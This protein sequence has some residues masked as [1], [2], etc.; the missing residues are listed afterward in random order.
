M[1][2]IIDI[3]EEVVTAIQNGED[4]RYDIHTAIAQ[5]IPY[6]PQ[7]D[8]ISREAL[9][10]RLIIN[11]SKKP[12]AQAI[13]QHLIDIVDDYPTVEIP[14]N[15]IIWEQGYECGKNERLQGEWKYHK[16]DRLFLP[17]MECSNCKVQD[18]LGKLTKK[19]YREVNHFCFNC[20]AKMKGGKE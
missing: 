4:Y 1:K 3:P 2:R 12:E 11:F 10:K 19:E 15:Q 18:L 14:C 6:E 9:K 7:G 16:G 5:G 17:Y 8:L 20:G 13:Y